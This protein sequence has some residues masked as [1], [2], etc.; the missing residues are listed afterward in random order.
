MNILF[1]AD[2]SSSIGTGHIMRDL[3]LASQYFQKGHNSIFA[4]QNLQGNINYKIEESGYK[5][6]ILKS[7]NI[8]ELNEII[9]KLKID[10]L[11]I[12][13]YGIDYKFEKKLKKKNLTLQMMVLD[14]TYE[15]HYC[16]ILLNHNISCDKKKY[17]SLVPSECKLKCG[18]KYT[19]IRDEFI[20]EKFIKRKI[21]KHDKKTIFVAMG[22]SDHSNITMKILKCIPKIYNVNIVT[23][24]SN[25]N[26]NQLKYFVSINNNMTLYIN[27]NNIAKLMH[28]SDMAIISPSVISHE[29]LYMQ[30]PFIS[31]LTGNDQ[32]DIYK[33]FKK[34]KLITMKKFN[35]KKLYKNILYLD[36]NLSKYRRKIKRISEK[37]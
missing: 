37:C 20:K 14:D 25:K 1:R 23:T 33:Y 16:D 6:I 30:L 5:T 32:K 24:T 8:Q 22:G 2:S 29:V 4:I 7:N 28:I 18:S 19:L 35:C 11:I 36:D 34:K 9:L 21:Y 31:I 13:H 27:T 12:D 3:V 17:K 26:L 10:L 15:K